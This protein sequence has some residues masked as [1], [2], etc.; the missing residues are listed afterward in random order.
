MT[1]TGSYAVD[2][3]FVQLQANFATNQQPTLQ[4]KSSFE[5]PSVLCLELT[6]P[7]TMLERSVNKKLQ[8]PGSGYVK[9]ARRVYRYKMAGYT[10]ALNQKNNE[11]C[12]Y[13]DSKR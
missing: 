2:T 6:Q 7:E 1:L 9:S 13:I 3:S 10:H 11:M 12:N 4:L 5:M 8:I